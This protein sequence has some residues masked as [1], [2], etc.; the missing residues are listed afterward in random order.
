ML[1]DPLKV[2]CRYALLV[3][4]FTET[5]D[6]KPVLVGAFERVLPMPQPNGDS[7]VS[8]GFLCVRLEASVAAGTKHELR[9]SLVDEHGQSFSDWNV[10]PMEMRPVTEG[11]GLQAA[12]SI[13]LG[14]TKVPSYGFYCWNIVVDGEVIAQCPMVVQQLVLPS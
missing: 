13:R 10:N 14:A 2:R 12:F 5:A 8:S 1:H 3:D 7:I 6:G 4:H 9:V 11:L